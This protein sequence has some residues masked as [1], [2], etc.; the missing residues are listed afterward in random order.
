MTENQLLDLA[1]QVGI[2]TDS[3]T[4]AALKL[5]YLHQLSFDKCAAQAGVAKQTVRYASSKIEA[6]LNPQP[7][8]V[9]ALTSPRRCMPEAQLLALCEL[10]GRL[11]PD[12]ATYAALRY[13]YV[14]GQSQAASAMQAGVHPSTVSNA[15]RRIEL[16]QAR[17]AG[18]AE[19]VRL[20]MG[21]KT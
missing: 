12:C 3:P 13:H 10:A 17:L 1:Q 9:R 21:E 6:A 7:A 16:T 15:Q 18:L 8:R 5:R 20:A 19:T 4:F 2:P 14:D 11:P